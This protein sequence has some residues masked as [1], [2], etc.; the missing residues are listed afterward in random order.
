MSIAAA[1]ALLAAAPAT[2][3]PTDSA[4]LD[5][6]TAA[7][8]APY[9]TGGDPRAPW[10]RDLWS[11]EI[12]Q[13]IAR[14]QSVVPEGEVD[15]LN[16]GDWLCQCQDW[17]AKAF[18]ARIASK[19]ASGPGVA[20]V[21]VNISIGF[22]VS[23]DAILVYRREDGVWRIDNLH[24]ESYTDGLKDALHQTIRTDEELKRP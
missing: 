9:R 15:D 12:A 3:N 6:A 24:A 20:E 7:A 17:D 14:W 4:A 23:R 19:Q 22:G 11:T 16:G 21:R 13:L 2:L 8:F 1:L 10:E 5:R 18:R